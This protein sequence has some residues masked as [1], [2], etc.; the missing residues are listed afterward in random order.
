MTTE[1]GLAPGTTAELSVRARLLADHLHVWPR[2][3]V[4]FA[5]LWQMWVEVEPVPPA[6]TT[7]RHGL[8]EV[9][10]E[11]VD[12]RLVSLSTT[13]ERSAPPALPTVVTLLGRPA[14]RATGADMARAVVW[15]P[16]LGFAATGRF[17]PSQVQTLVNVNTWLRDHGREHDV[18]PMR[19]RSLQ[20]L[21]DEKAL[22][23][24]LATELFGLGR[25][26][27]ELLR[28]YRAHPPLPAAQVGEGPVV[29]VVENSDTFHSLR[30]LLAADPGRVGH[31]AW[32][33]GGMFEATF[34]S[35]ADLPGAALVAYFGDID[36][37]G[38]R[39]PSAAARAAA[40]E[41]ALPVVPA[42]GLYRALLATGVTGPGG[43]YDADKVAAFAE[44][45]TTPDLVRGA[46]D[47]LARGRRT[48]QEALNRTRLAVDHSW[49]SGP[50]I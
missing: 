17:T 35:A 24:V 41:G 6:D 28:T 10:A 5:E 13:V 25:L 20:V 8:A 38:L 11:L 34:R 40:A 39:I 22:E 7:R 9:L 46:V 37:D 4:R 36:T 50:L 42:T 12:A 26:S 47:L 49:K 31:V 43:A 3:T 19:E 33:A 16:E 32:G 30:A 44:W 18:L 21:G 29:L 1:P 45:L 14:P 2:A 23:A 48:P 27:L 15:R